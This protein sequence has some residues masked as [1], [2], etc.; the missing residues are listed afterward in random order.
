MCLHELFAHRQIIFWHKK[1]CLPPGAG[2]ELQVALTDVN[3]LPFRENE[4]TDLYSNVSCRQ[5]GMYTGLWGW[6]S[7]S[8]YQTQ[9][10]PSAPEIQEARG[11]STL[12]RC[13]LAP[14]WARGSPLTVTNVRHRVPS[15]LSLNILKVKIMLIWSKSFQPESNSDLPQR[16]WWRSLGLPS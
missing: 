1:S 15:R 5:W 7:S 11:G 2:S 16:Q 3:Q 13:S 10:T 8:W 14:V 9:M 4:G 6:T 12:S